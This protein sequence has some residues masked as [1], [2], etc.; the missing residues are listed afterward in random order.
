MASFSQ[1][2]NRIALGLLV[3]TFTPTYATSQGAYLDSLAK[4]C[5]TQAEQL[6][7]GLN[8]SYIWNLNRTVEQMAY[9]RTS[10][11]MPTVN[12]W[13]NTPNS[14][15]PRSLQVCIYGPELA[16]RIARGSLMLRLTIIPLR[17]TV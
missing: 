4:L 8:T 16:W 12:G 10:G 6:G 15:L 11:W 9:S 17:L 3:I 7:N 1:L 14:T 2:V 5:D 13:P